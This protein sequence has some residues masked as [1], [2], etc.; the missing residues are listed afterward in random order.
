MS[1]CLESGH[2]HQE[3][4]QNVLL[5]LLQLLGAQVRMQVNLTLEFLYVGLELLLQRDQSLLGLL[6][7]FRARSSRALR[8]QQREL[9]VPQELCCLSN[10]TC[11]ASQRLLGLGDVLLKY[12]KHNLLNNC[13]L[14]I[15]GLAS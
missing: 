6:Q 3:L 7:L 15:L 13:T 8:W 9:D 5:E 12:N 11:V 1:P 10:S 14:V 2:P 4:A